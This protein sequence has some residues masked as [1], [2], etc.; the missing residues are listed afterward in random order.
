MRIIAEDANGLRTR[1]HRRVPQRRGGRVRDQICSEN[2]Q[3]RSV[4]HERVLSKAP[5]L[6][7]DVAKAGRQGVPGIP[8]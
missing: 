7:S 6:L 1:G 8:R 3:V 5:S 2:L 4:S